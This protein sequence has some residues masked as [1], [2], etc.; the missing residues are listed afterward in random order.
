MRILVISDLHA[1]PWALAAVEQDAGPVDGILCAGDTVNYGPDPHRVI[2]WL[3]QHKVPTTL[4]NH[5]HAVAFHADPKASPAKQP[6]ALAMRDWTR[7]QLDEADLAWLLSLPRQVPWA[8]G[9]CQFLMMHAT[10]LDPL[11]DYRLT[12]KASE[13]LLSEI[14][15]GVDADVLILGH[16]HLPLLREGRSLKVL[17]PGSVG[18]PLDGDPRAAYAIWEDGKIELRRV[19]YDQNAL[20]AGLRAT[21]L[22][23]SQ[24]DDLSRI[25]QTGTTS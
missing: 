17:N 4:G 6:L 18:Q 19:A 21:P 12:P 7:R 20:L 13:R 3:R 10:P 14:L 8:A 25:I 2:T 1:N 5:D 16:T 24:I 22:S 15:A 23:S 11:Y 9:G